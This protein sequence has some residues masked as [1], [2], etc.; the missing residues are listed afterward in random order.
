[1]IADGGWNN[2]PILSF[3]HLKGIGDDRPA[4]ASEVSFVFEDEIGE[5]SRPSNCSAPA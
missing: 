4:F 3:H 2:H 5:L 1:M